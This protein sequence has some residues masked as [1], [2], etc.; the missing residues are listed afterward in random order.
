MKIR[1]NSPYLSFY[2]VK[3]VFKHCVFSLWMWLESVFVSFD[4]CSVHD[5]IEIYPSNK[6]FGS[7]YNMTYV[8]FIRCTIKDTYIF[9]AIK[10]VELVRSIGF[11]AGSPV[12]HFTISNSSINGGGIDMV[13][14]LSTAVVNVQ[15]TNTS[16]TNT[17][18]RSYTRGQTPFFIHNCTF[19]QSSLQSNGFTIV[20]IV[21][22][23][24]DVECQNEG[25]ALSFTGQNDV[26]P[27]HINA[28]CDLFQIEKCYGIYLSN[29]DFIASKSEALL[30]IIEGNQTVIENCTFSMSNSIPKYMAENLIFEGHGNI[31]KMINVKVNVTKVRSLYNIP[32][33][34]INTA[35][36]SSVLLFCQMSFKVI[37]KISEKGN[38]SQFL[39][40][41]DVCQNTEY[42]LMGH[43]KLTSVTECVATKQSMYSVN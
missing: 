40:Q 31:V 26:D 8:L 17:K 6:L 30:L 42:S 43:S 28:M 35:E 1:R 11:S 34:S 10:E 22:S 7:D 24:F 20:C 4:N 37:E 13:A 21:N 25:C 33:F 29:S 18:V 14:P 39:C 36:L 27:S 41:K 16:L 38:N 3:A 15:I 2:V 23:K 9:V 19:N 12:V 5:S 32:L